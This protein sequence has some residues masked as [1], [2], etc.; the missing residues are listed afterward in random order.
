MK[1][2]QDYSS[3]YKKLGIPATARPSAQKRIKREKHKILKIAGDRRGR[4]GK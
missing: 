3:P 2:K 4:K 1:K